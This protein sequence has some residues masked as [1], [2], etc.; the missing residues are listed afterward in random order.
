MTI[1]LT[2]QRRAAQM[3]SGPPGAS[4]EQVVRRLL[5]VQGQD[6]RGARAAGPSERSTNSP[7]KGAP[8]SRTG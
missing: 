7:G 5:A 8:N 2:A 1:V 3:L 4:A 6:G